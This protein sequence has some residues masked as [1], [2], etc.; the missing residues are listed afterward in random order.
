[1]EMTLAFV[2]VIL[3]AGGMLAVSGLAFIL[4]KWLEEWFFGID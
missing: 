2:T 4:L 3:V 1:M